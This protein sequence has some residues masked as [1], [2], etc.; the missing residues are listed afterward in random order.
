MKIKE[1]SFE[2]ERDRLHLEMMSAV[3]H[4]LKTPLA[5]IIGS[6]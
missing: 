2:Q 5:S 3:S 6:L 4:D 1:E